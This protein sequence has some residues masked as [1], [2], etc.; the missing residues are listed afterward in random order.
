MLNVC[1]MVS[2]DALGIECLLIHRLSDSLRSR[3]RLLP[4][5]SLSRGRR[6][7]QDRGDSELGLNSRLLHLL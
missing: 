5:E 2:P 1:K 6:T 7:P 4:H 3:P